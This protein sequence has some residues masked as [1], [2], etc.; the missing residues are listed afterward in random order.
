MYFLKKSP[1]ENYFLKKRPYENYP[2]NNNTIQLIIIG[3]F[4]KYENNTIGACMGL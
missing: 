3:Q 2:I 4:E 1:Y